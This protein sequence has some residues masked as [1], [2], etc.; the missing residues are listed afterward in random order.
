MHRREPVSPL[1]RAHTKEINAATLGLHPS[2]MGIVP[3]AENRIQ[4]E[5]RRTEDDRMHDNREI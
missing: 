5:I 1:I 4:L 2:R 3:L